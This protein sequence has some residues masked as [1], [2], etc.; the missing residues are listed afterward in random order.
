GASSL[1][2][3][4]RQPGTCGRSEARPLRPRADPSLDPAATLRGG[5]H[6]PV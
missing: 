2:A 6:R 4:G 3:C 5:A 1:P